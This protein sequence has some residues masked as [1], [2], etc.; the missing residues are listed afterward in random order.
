MDRGIG[1]NEMIEAI[2]RDIGGNVTIEPIDGSLVGKDVELLGGRLG[3]NGIQ[4]LGECL[5]R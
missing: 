1:G 5:G 2:G 4:P 3:D